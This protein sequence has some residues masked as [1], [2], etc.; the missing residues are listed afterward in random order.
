MRLKTLK[1]GAALAC[2]VLA[3]AGLSASAGGDK[4]D[5]DDKDKPALSG[6]WVRKGG[7]KRHPLKIE[8]PGKDVMKIFPH[9]ENEA[10][11]I[12][13]KVTA[14]KGGLVKAKVTE[15]EGKE[16]VKEK[17]KEVVPV[18]LAFSFKWQAKD[19]TATLDGLKGDKAEGLKSHLEGKYDR[20]K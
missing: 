12:S 20:K 9:G 11:I 17:V 15:L 1:Y 4:D 2:G 7:D 16:E 10:I 14:G 19:D 8:F 13:C 5:K 6:V 18:G 3:L